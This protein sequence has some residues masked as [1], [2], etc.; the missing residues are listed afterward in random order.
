MDP[1]IVIGIAVVVAVILVMRALKFVPQGYTYTV[2][3]FGKY[4]R[5]LQPGIGYINSSRALAISTRYLPVS[6][7]K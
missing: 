6:D 7:A 3:T 1:I 4:T 5:T 2:E